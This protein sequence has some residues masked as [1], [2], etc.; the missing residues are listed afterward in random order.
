MM[1]YFFKIIHIIFLYI[2]YYIQIN[3]THMSTSKY[4]IKVCDELFL[5]GTDPPCTMYNYICVNHANYDDNNSCECKNSFYDSSDC[6]KCK[7]SDNDP[8]NSCNCKN[9]IKNR[10][11]CSCSSS[12]IVCNGICKKPTCG[13]YKN[14]CPNSIHRDPCSDSCKCCSGYA[15]PTYGKN[16]DK[17]FSVCSNKNKIMASNGKCYTQCGLGSV[18]GKYYNDNNVEGSCKSYI[19]CPIGKIPNKFKGNTKSPDVCEVII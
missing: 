5:A 11:D 2:I 12:N 14:V 17:C 7:Y 1:I 15:N 13:K 10:N 8:N 18:T 9:G 4:V 6:R 19:Y 16:V 3:I